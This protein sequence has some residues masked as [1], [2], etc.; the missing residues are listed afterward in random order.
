MSDENQIISI[1]E[2]T[3]GYRFDVWL[4]GRLHSANTPSEVGYKVELFLSAW[5]PP[6]P[7]PR[8]L[9]EMDKMILKFLVATPY[10]GLL[11]DTPLP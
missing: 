1:E 11:G 4:D 3:D 6:V 8:E 9:S 7:E 5:R 2:G 10:K